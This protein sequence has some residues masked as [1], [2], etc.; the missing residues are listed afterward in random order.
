MLGPLRTI[1]GTSSISYCIVTSW[2]LSLSDAQRNRQ[3]G[4][5]SWCLL[6]AASCIIWVIEMRFQEIGIWIQPCA[7]MS[8]LE[9]AGGFHY[10]DRAKFTCLL[11]LFT[12]VITPGHILLPCLSFSFEFP[13]TC[14]SAIAPCL[15]PWCFLPQLTTW[16]RPE[17]K[18]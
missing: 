5:T 17:W 3:L 11:R 16:H 4:G 15:P 18:T 2:G 13:P 6:F 9:L 12:I 14:C 1:F 8:P 10:R 7:W